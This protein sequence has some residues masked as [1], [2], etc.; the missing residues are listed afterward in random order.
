MTTHL[1][2]MDKQANHSQKD[3]AE[4]D[5]NRASLRD[6]AIFPP[7]YVETTVP[8][9][10]AL[11]RGDVREDTHL[12]VIERK[13][14]MLALLTKQMIYHHVAQGEIDGEPWMVSL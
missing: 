13:A 3:M 8:L 1:K 4:F 11:T 2:K 5:S 10:E 7:V 12:M 9:S 14:R 6:K